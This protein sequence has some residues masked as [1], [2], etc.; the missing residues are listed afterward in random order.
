MAKKQMG[1]SSANNKSS[2]TRTKK[3]AA[4]QKTATKKSTASV[5]KSA[6]AKAKVAP[7]PKA[8]AR[9]KKETILEIADTAVVKQVSDK[10]VSSIKKSEHWHTLLFALI[11]ILAAYFSY[12]ATSQMGSQQVAQ[13]T[14]QPEA[15]QT[16][17]P[18]QEAAQPAFNF[19]TDYA[20]LTQNIGSD[21]TL[22]PGESGELVLSVKNTGK[23]TWY[24]DGE[25][26]FRLGTLQPENE[27]MPFMAASVIGEDQLREAVNRNR[28]E[29]EQQTVAPGEVANFRLNVKAV[30]W[31]NQPL[32]KGRYLITVG[33]LVE[34]KGTLSKNPLTWIV[35]V[36]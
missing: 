11:V 12:Q 10:V 8:A 19:P 1:G 18:V 29:M 17:A 25:N 4:S 24:R 34:G 16:P 31:D 5:T 36:R 13:P 23:A 22:A 21:L 28:V 6:S 20:W 33:F 14:G 3:P 35:N 27:H 26:P 7:K 2:S 15:T 32:A 30:N 9:S